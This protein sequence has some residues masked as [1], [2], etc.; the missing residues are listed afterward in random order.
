[1]ESP[2]SND[3]IKTIKPIKRIE[4]NCHIPDLGQAFLDVTEGVSNLIVY[5]T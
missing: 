4:N 5:V 2:L 1:M 3:K